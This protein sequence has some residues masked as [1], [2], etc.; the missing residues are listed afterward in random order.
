MPARCSADGRAEG[1]HAQGVAAAAAGLGGPG[2]PADRLARVGIEHRAVHV[3]V[4]VLIVGRGAA[5]GRHLTRLAHHRLG[6]RGVLR[7]G[8]ADVGGVDLGGAGIALRTLGALSAGVAL[9]AGD[10]GVAL[11]AGDAGV[12]LGAG[13]AGVALGAGDAGI[14][15]GAGD[16]GIALVA[17]VS[18]GARGARAAL[19]ALQRGHEVTDGAGVTG[20]EPELISG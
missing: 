17:L 8:T 2:L 10:A 7:R 15:L 13:D 18:L 3:Q 12:A 6:L 14:A 1:V 11:G 19:I 4:V 20:V 9:G 16:A 5:S